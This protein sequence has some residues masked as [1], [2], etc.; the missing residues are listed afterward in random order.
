MTKMVDGMGLG[1]IPFRF[2]D[3]VGYGHNGGID[4]FQSTMA[5]FPDEKVAVAFVANGIDF[6][7]NRIGIAVLSA[8]FDQKLDLPSFDEVQ[9]AQETLRRYEGV[10]SSKTIPLKITVRIND[11]KLTAQ[12]TGQGAFPLTPSSDVMFRFAPAGVV[13]TF[14]E[15][16]PGKGFN[17]LRLQQAGQDLKFAKE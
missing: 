7:L 14:A 3:K 13:I 11:K 10:Y 17:V 9:V 12:A 5:Y 1:L 2:G 4:G 16:T 8:S 6:S 15:S